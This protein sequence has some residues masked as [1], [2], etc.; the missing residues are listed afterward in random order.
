MLLNNYV[1]PIN[2]MDERN[3]IVDNFYFFC[4]T[5]RTQEDVDRV[6]YLTRVI[7][8][9]ENTED[10]WK[11]FQMNLRGALNYSDLD[12]I[13]KN[14]NT[15]S[16]LLNIPLVSME[17]PA[18]PRIPYFNNLLENVRRIRV[19]FYHYATT[20]QVPSKPLNTFQ[21][22]N[23]IERI[24]RDAYSVYR[25]NTETF[26]YCGDDVYAGEYMLL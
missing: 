1:S 9:G 10:E 26:F 24:L 8:A 15:L 21:K 3:E 14:L 20:P 4:I 13:E 2:Y 25:R 12:R 16:T 11:E 17:R 7:L 6:K 22:I 18:I 19:S 23:D 5:D